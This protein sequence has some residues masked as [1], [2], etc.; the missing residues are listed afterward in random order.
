MDRIFAPDRASLV[1]H[2]LPAVPRLRIAAKAIQQQAQ[3]AKITGQRQALAIV[4]DGG[5]GKSVLLGQILDYLDNNSPD[6]HIDSLELPFGAAVLVSCASIPPTTELFDV[7]TADKALGLAADP[8]GRSS[9]GLL[10]LLASLKAEYTVVS[11]LID[12]LDLLI[13]EQT[14]PA[15]SNLIAEALDTSSVVM[16]CRSYEFRN[17]FAELRQGA[18]RLVHRLNGLN[19]PVLDAQEIVAWAQL[20]INSDN[21]ARTAAET[22]FL[23]GL[24][25]GIEQSGSLRQLCAVPVR[26]AITC[27]TFAAAGHVPEDLTVVELYDAYWDRRIHRDIGKSDTSAAY[28]K[29]QAVLSLASHVITPSG[30]ILLQ[31]P[32]A[33][34]GNE[35]LSG[36]RLL[37]SEGVVRD[38]NISWEF[39]HQTFA[40]YAYAR[41]LLTNGIESEQVIELSLRLQAGQTNLWPIA[42]SLLLQVADYHDYMTLAG[43]FPPLGPEGARVHTLAALR[44]LE[45]DALARVLREVNDDTTL[46][47]AVLPALGD[48]PTRHLETAFNATL[49]SI[50]NH[51]EELTDA[52]AATLA[53][54]LPRATPSAV[55]GLFDTALDALIEVR[56][57]Y[58]QDGRDYL[59]SSLLRPLVDLPITTDLLPIMR[60]RY[61]TLGAAGRQAAIRAHLNR[62]LTEDQTVDFARSILRTPC[63]PLRDDEQVLLLQLLWDCAAVRADRMWQSWR[64]LLNDD[65]GRSWGGVQIKFVAHLADEHV[66]IREEFLADLLSGDAQTPDKYV[67]VF[68]QLA[69]KQA[70][71]V[72]NWLLA[73]PST[74]TSLAIGAITEGAEALTSGSSSETRM[75]LISW[76]TP[77]RE[78]TPRNAWA[79]QIILAG[80]VTPAH[81]RIF[82][83]LIGSVE[84]GQ[85]LNSALEVWLF[86]TPRHVLNEL[87]SQF[88][89]LLRAGD[90]ETR[91]RRARLEGR[92][93]DEDES[94]RRWIENVVL[95]GQSP[96]IAG[97]ALKTIEEAVRAELEM[98][99]SDMV[100]W[101]GTLLPTVHTDTARRI[102]SIL[103]DKRDVDDAKLLSAAPILTPVVIDRMRVAAQL[104]E[105]SQLSRELLEVLV[106]VD[107]VMPMTPEDVRKVY[108][109]VRSR[110]PAAGS[111]GNLG[112]VDEQAAALRDLS[113]LAG[114]LMSKRLPPSEVRDLI[115]EVLHIV[116]LNHLGNSAEKIISSMLIGLGYRDL[117]AIEWMEE[118]FIDV[119]YDVSLKLAI[120]EAL[121]R[122]DGNH[123]GGRASVLKDRPDIPQVVAAYIVSRLHA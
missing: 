71:W 5:M 69:K 48:A 46:M 123:I 45:A 95:R 27:E 44:R 16:T 33:R 23:L 67:T 65:F 117:G 66:T 25:G 74:S 56:P 63:P 40:E 99:S 88:R 113:H 78:I 105:D 57:H 101:L 26:L 89:L 29:E 9:E 98:I 4:G 76:L 97:T 35:N 83:E 37:A 80:G 30:S 21:T 72:V 84:S 102:C 120:A 3:H 53:L 109:F 55:V 22:A 42:A 13:N 18:P 93:A 49:D 70:Q 86:Q 41:W 77:G 31:M 94:A 85:V 50:R 60:K 121:L 34:V 11:L 1:A 12:T 107:L 17:Y 51:P 119:N 81:Q 43:L 10:G 91:R 39:F 96:R 24:E 15:L 59:P 2:T 92:L 28:A 112:K 32:K 6:Q 52:G 64:D 103:S 61:S 115:S 116:D 47:L 118:L 73:R 106:E 122:V 110:L 7:Q 79:A 62:P 14:L 90:A 114:T 8:L 54:L 108:N 104:G 19:L 75:E 111:A 36:L 100:A 38:R 58:P 68:K 82:N 87:T 20:Y